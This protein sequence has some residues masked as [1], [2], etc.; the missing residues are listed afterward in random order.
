MVA[1]LIDRG[2]DGG[3]FSFLLRHLPF[4]GG[5]LRILFGGLAEQEAAMQLD[6]VGRCLLGRLEL[7]ERIVLSGQGRPQPGGVELSRH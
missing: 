2:L 6:Q 3:A 7:G 5:N 1:E 4:Y